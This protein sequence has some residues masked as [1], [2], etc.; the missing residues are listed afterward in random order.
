LILDVCSSV[1]QNKFHDKISVTA[2]LS[3]NKMVG[4]VER[5]I[6]WISCN[7][8][9]ASDFERHCHI[10]VGVVRLATIRLMLQPLAAR[11]PSQI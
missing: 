8:R 10:A 11:T 1:P 4:I 3:D 9:L 2:Q 6:G 7:Q 5:T